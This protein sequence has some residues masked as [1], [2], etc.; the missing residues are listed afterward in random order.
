MF[1]ADNMIYYI[2]IH[3]FDIE[4][5]IKMNYLS[6]ADVAKKWNISERSVRNYCSKG[7]IEG[8]FLTGKTWNTGIVGWR[9]NKNGGRG[10]GESAWNVASWTNNKAYNFNGS[11]KTL[12]FPIHTKYGTL[13]EAIDAWS[14]DGVHSLFTILNFDVLASN[15]TMKEVANFRMFVTNLRLVPYVTPEQ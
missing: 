8:A 7:R 11:W 3:I 10:N 13:G 14:T 2:K 15:L 4:G 1:F 6:V 9:M 12:T 5:D